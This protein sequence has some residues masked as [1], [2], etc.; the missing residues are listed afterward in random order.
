MDMLPEYYSSPF[1]SPH[2]ICFKAGRYGYPTLTDRYLGFYTGRNHLSNGYKQGGLLQYIY[3]PLVTR[4]YPGALN[5]QSVRQDTM[6]IANLSGQATS[7]LC[8]TCRPN[9]I[10]HEAYFGG[11]GTSQQVT[12]FNEYL[13]DFGQ[14]SRQRAEKA[15]PSASRTDQP[16]SRSLRALGMFVDDFKMRRERLGY[17]Q[18]NVGK[19][20]CAYVKCNMQYCFV[21]LVRLM[22]TR[23]NTS[24]TLWYLLIP[25]C[26]IG[27]MENARFEN[28]GRAK[29]EETHDIISSLT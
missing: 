21:P 6:G 29:L 14:V 11:I 19:S 9:P 7:P 26:A 5:P 22:R 8:G 23:R 10:P 16:D 3:V 28:E 13:P 25:T 20:V 24:K 17:S 4:S 27:D 15:T 18:A 2:G 12:N 1:S